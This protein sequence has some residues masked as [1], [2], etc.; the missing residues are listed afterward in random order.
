MAVNDTVFI[1]GEARLYKSS[2][3]SIAA[4]WIDGQAV[5]IHETTAA[6][7]VTYNGNGST[8]GS[9][10][11]DSTGYYIGDTVYVSSTGSLLKSGYNF[12]S[13]NTTSTG[14]GISYDPSDTFLMGSTGIILYA[15]WDTSYTV[16]YNGNTNTSGSVPIDPNRYAQGE[17]ITVL[18]NSGSLKKTGYR[19]AGW[20]ILA[21][22]A[23][24]TYLI[25]S[26]FAMGSSNITLYALWIPALSIII[27]TRE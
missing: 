22:G 13:W 20:N 16:T 5:V 4:A 25:N 10:P 6:H 7:S 21:N 17:T 3:S 19:F 8:S 2:G 23:G 11:I 27:R 15:Q 12:S 1:D 24:T 14:N 18:T 26:T 9:V